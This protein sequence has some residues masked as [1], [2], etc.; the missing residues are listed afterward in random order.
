MT[1]VNPLVSSHVVIQATTT[2]TRPEERQNDLRVEQIVRATVVEGGLDKALL[3]LKGQKVLIQSEQELQT[4]Q[5]LQLQVLTT[6]PKLSFKLLATP[7]ESH[8]ASLLPLL[9]KP[10]NWDSL[11]QQV[12][13]GMKPQSE[14]M[15]QT[16]E[17]LSTFLRPQTE[18][19]TQD[20]AKIASVLSQLKTSTPLFSGTNGPALAASIDRLLTA[21]NWQVESPDLATQLKAIAVQFRQQPELM[22]EVTRGEQEKIAGLL[23]QIDQTLKPLQPEQARHLAAELK[24]RLAAHPTKL[25][26]LIMPGEPTPLP[27]QLKT[28]VQLI[29]QQPN[30]IH[31]FRGIDQE[32]LTGILTQIGQTHKPLQFEQAQHLATELKALLSTNPA[33]F[34][35]LIGGASQK[36]PFF[37]PA[38]PAT[39]ELS[40][41]LLGQMMGLFEQLELAVAEQP[42]WPQD[43][44]QIVQQVL[45]AMQPLLSEPEILIKSENLGIFSQLFGLNLEA[46]LLRGKTRDALSSL[47]LALLGERTELGPKGEEAIHRIELFQICRV[48]LAE[49]NLT[50]VPLPLPFLEEGF[51]LVEEHNPKDQ[52]EETEGK[53]TQLSLHL[54]LSYLGNLRIDMLSEPS[55]MSL[56]FACEDQQRVNFLQSLN[57]QLQERLQDLNI[58]GTSFTTGA[59]TP[60][61]VLLKKLLP[62]AHRVLDDRV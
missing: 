29:Q 2:A 53:S 17:K 38:Q 50:F 40:P 33:Q 49:Q 56:R 22:H 20:I 61:N 4:G 11:T 23:K 51:L 34:T 9:A 35:Q 59:E 36:L 52:Q 8:L 13:Q 1:I 41:S 57:D 44:R 39:H 21:L 48:R 10:F 47:K 62:A 16:L 46:E 18:V 32:R 24:P 43:L 54:R 37:L 58:R 55:G 14:P 12:Q 27:Q 31:E 5:K 3:D 30:L 6:H 7:L 28:M 60:A 19:P 25:P 45:G 42:I 26:Q 15:K